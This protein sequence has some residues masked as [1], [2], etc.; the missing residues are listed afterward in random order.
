MKKPLRTTSSNRSEDMDQTVMAQFIKL[1]KPI[2]DK[3]SES[4]HRSALDAES[5]AQDDED[6]DLSEDESDEEN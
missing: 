3:S 5:D 6:M 4:D 2:T 1:S